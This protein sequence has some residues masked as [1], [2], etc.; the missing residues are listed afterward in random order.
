MRS[1]RPAADARI[2]ELKDI[3]EYPENKGLFS[4]TKVCSLFTLIVF[5]A[6]LKLYFIGDLFLIR[7]NNFLK[8]REYQ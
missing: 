4:K 8:N 3:D 1:A 6:F 5:R 2:N 7:L